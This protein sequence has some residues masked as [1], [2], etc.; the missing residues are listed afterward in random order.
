[1]ESKRNMKKNEV[2]LRGL[3]A[4]P[5]RTEVL[6][7]NHWATEVLVELG[8]KFNGTYMHMKCSFYWLPYG[9][10]ENV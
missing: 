8:S 5:F 7:C 4:M 3:N 6:K 10:L 9:S 2:P 1:M